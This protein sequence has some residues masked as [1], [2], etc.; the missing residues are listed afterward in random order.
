MVVGGILKKGKGCDGPDSYS[1][2]DA[3]LDEPVEVEATAG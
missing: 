3:S 1:G 2:L